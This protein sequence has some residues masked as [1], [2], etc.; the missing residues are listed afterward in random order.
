MAT[1][2]SV[3]SAFRLALFASMFLVLAFSHP[4]F[5]ATPFTCEQTQFNST[6]EL[7]GI[8]ALAMFALIALVYIGGEAT[9]NPRMLTWAKTEAM[10]AFASL[11]IV[12]IVLFVVSTM[13]DFRVG[14][15]SSLVNSTS[16]MPQIY[17]LAPGTAANGNDTLYN[18]AMRYVE[19]LA[20]VSLSNVNSLRY[21]LGAYEI[22]TSYSKFVCH[23]SCVYSLSSTS[24]SMFGGE[25]AN[26]AITN[27]LLGVGTVTY[28]SAV[29]QYFILVYIYGGLFTVFL[30]LAIV[31]RSVPFMRHFGGSL[32]AIFV[33]LYILYPLMLVADAY[34]APGFAASSSPVKMCD[35]DGRNCAGAGIFSTATTH[36]V[37]CINETADS[38]CTLRKE[39]DME[40][41]GI[42]QHDMDKLQ[43]NS[44]PAAIRLNVLL[45][46][47]AVFLS[48]LNF[49]V[50]AAFGRE[51]SRFLGEEADMSRLGQMI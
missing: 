19:N 29:F 2:D 14:E 4:V 6:M 7:C 48:S 23:G 49:I 28:L 26:L 12:S 25:S 32:I 16:S 39:W 24:V 15:I 1:Q 10:Q 43:P 44:L 35:R 8:A 42:T 30:P 3:K 33:A 22:R 45:F 21:D 5:A 40:G 18:G 34:I 51:L 46:L 17:K 13:C 41:V 38:Q 37:T 50:I 20:A 31:I 36:G 9:Q 47:A 11:V 27:N